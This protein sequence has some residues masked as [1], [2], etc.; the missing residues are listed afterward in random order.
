MTTQPFISFITVTF[1]AEAVLPPTLDR[2][3]EQSDTS[4]EC[5]VIDGASTDATLDLIKQYEALFAQKGIPFRWISEPDEGLYYAMNKGLALAQGLYVWFMNAGDRLHGTD[6]VERLKV[7]LSSMNA[8]KTPNTWPDFIHGETMIVDERYNVLGPRRLKAPENLTWKHFRK[9]MLVC[10][11][12]MLVKRNLAPTYDVRYM[13]SA[14]VDWSIRSLK[15]STLIHHTP[16]VLCDFQHG[17]ITSKQMKAS[18]KERFRIMSNHYGL[19]TTLLLH[20]WFILRAGWF[21]L[22]HGWL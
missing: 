16:L 14:D 13:Y 11:Q 10:H 3:L 15:A 6:T 2:F 4:F 7:E 19:T 21:K 8:R 17:G 20:T 18:L 12:A 9:G 22:R 1:Q 5:L